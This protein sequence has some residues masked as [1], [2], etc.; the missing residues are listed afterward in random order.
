MAP[1]EFYTG[2]CIELNNCA[3]SVLITGSGQLLW[4]HSVYR[5]RRRL[6][7]TSV[8]EENDSSWRESELDSR[9]S[10]V[11]YT[12]SSPPGECVSIANDNINGGDGITI[13]SSRHVFF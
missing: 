4:Q 9:L 7:S 10:R 13:A 11:E 2:F 12:G 6:K 5:G 8:C 1:D 3:E